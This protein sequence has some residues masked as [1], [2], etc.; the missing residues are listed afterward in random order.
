MRHNGYIVL[1]SAIFSNISL[2][3]VVSV[4]RSISQNAIRNV[5]NRVYTAWKRGCK[6]TVLSDAGHP[7]LGGL[8]AVRKKEKKKAQQK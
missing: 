8:R 3:I 6:K 2:T 4:Y 7:V 5:T 1:Q